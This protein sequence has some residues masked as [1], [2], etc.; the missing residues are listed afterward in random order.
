MFKIST[1]WALMLV[2]MTSYCQ[3]HQPSELMDSLR[4][5]LKNARTDTLR[6]RLL[7]SIGNQISISDSI[8]GL[9]YLREAL[10]L[11]IVAKNDYY[12]ANAYSALARF[13]HVYYQTDSAIAYYVKAEKMLEKYPEQQEFQRLLLLTKLNHLVLQSKTDPNIALDQAYTLIPIAEEVDD[14]VTLGNIYNNIGVWFMNINQYENAIKYFEKSVEVKLLEHRQFARFAYSYINIA[15]C[16]HRTEKTDKMLPYLEEAK[17]HLSQAKDRPEIWGWYYNYY[18]LYEYSKKRYGYAYTLLNKGLQIAKREKDLLAQGN[19]LGTL[20]KVSKAKGNYKQALKYAQ[21]DYEFK[22][23]GQAKFNKSGA[24]LDIAEINEKLG[25]Y[26]QAYVA[27]RTYADVVDSIEQEEKK[28][29][30]LEIEKKFETA[31]NEKKILQLQ[32]ENDIKSFA[33]QKNRLYTGLLTAISLLLL[34]LVIL[35]F[36]FNRNNRKQLIQHKQLHQLEMEKVNQQN[37]ISLLSAMLNGQESER[38]RIAKDLHD[39]LGG[40]LSVLKL[41]LTGTKDESK[42]ENISILRKMDY[43]VDELRLISHN[44]MPETLIKY[45]LGE[46]ITSYCMRMRNSNKRVQLTCQIFHY[47]NELSPEKELILYRIMQELVTNAFKHA[48]ATTIF[49]QLLKSDNK[50]TLTVEDNGIGFNRELLLK[51]RKGA[52][53]TNILSRIEYINGELDIYTEPGNG[54]TFTVECT[55]L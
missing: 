35:Y 8:G 43:A 27:M 16:L 5:E 39:G 29:N 10:S 14:Q 22:K 52:G 24:L 45:G 46:T 38:T 9:K 55:I 12:I 7:V 54:S 4:I 13:N 21:S 23:T 36:Q 33:L 44:L 53:L 11:A 40:L 2:F 17:K 30:L 41:E 32:H 18:G 50:T 6:S 26:K 47:Q 20:V 15:A 31:S 49:V 25:Y 48:N 28:N 42:S 51:N 19:I 34:T 37:K 3:P 1:C